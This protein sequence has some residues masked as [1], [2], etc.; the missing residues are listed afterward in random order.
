MS[1]KQVGHG[2]AHC[3]LRKPRRSAAVAVHT[4]EIALN[5]ADGDVGCTPRFNHACK[6]LIAL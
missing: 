2:F 6:L 1:A 4:S 3:H 5:V